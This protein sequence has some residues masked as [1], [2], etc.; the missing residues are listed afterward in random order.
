MRLLLAEDE[1]ELSDALVTVLKYNHYSV[2]AVYD[3]EEALQ[4][5]ET[6]N[7]DGVI[8]DIMMP[9]MDGIQVLTQ[10]RSKGNQVPILMLTAKAEVDDKVLGLD[11][12]ANDYLT[13]PFAMKELLA[14]IRAMTRQKAEP[15]NTLRFGNI[16]LDR[17]NFELKGPGGSFQLANKEYQMLELLM[18]NAGQVIP[19]DRFLEKIWGYD[20]E[21]EAQV[22]W[23]YL[24]YLR[25]KLT[26][27]KADVKIRA[28]RN[29]GYV[30]EE[31]A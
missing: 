25:K 3:G 23:V 30:L 12:G 8:L 20:S 28:R 1:K 2:D 31:E 29:A 16:S 21:T 6:E 14:R 24:S 7:Y 10:V 9:K 26:A 18:A 22:V 15:D 17:G 5:L 13:K 11:R 4:Y 19:T 27:V